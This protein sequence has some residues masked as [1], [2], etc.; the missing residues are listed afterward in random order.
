MPARPARSHSSSL[1]SIGICGFAIVPRILPIVDFAQAKKFAALCGASVPSWLEAEFG[2]AGED[3]SSR[4]AVSERV[5]I[6]QCRRLVAAGVEALHF[7]TL[8]RAELI[9]AICA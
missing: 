3:P 5:A 9:S 4:A 8:N 6:A 7:Y 1:M 2:R